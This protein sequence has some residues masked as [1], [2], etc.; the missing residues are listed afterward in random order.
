MVNLPVEVIEQDRELDVQEQVAGSALS[1]LRWHWTLDESNPDAVTCAEYARQVGAHESTIHEYA[2]GWAMIV[3]GLKPEKDLPDARKL[4][5]MSQERAA[6]TE[7]VAKA[8][9]ISVS[10]AK[11]GRKDDV[12]RVREAMD[13]YAEQHPEST[14]DDRAEI[15]RRT[16]KNISVSRK[17]ERSQRDELLTSQPHL[18]TQIQGELAKGR[19]ALTA[20]KNLARDA[21]P[22]VF[23]PEYLE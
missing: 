16:A 6:A 19:E 21:S 3:L 4:S 10:R 15:A 13:D 17:L 2:D 7:A 9:G 11:D 23:A 14:P 5:Q 18:L 12:K 8:E 1:E 22:D 20:A